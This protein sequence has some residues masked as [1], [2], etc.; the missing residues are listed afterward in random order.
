MSEAFCFPAFNMTDI[1]DDVISDTQYFVFERRL[2][3]SL[4]L[5]CPL[6]VIGQLELM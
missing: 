4:R 3:D 5:S 2:T 1:S 6:P